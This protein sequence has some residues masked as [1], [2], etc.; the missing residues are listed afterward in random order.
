MTYVEM[1]ARLIGFDTTSRNSNLALIAFVRDYLEGWGVASELVFDDSGAKANLIAT[2]GPPERAGL[3][4]SGHTDVVPVDGQH[5]ASDPFVCTERD[6]RLHGRGA[7]D[8]K[9]FIAT[10]L[11]LVPEF[12]ARPLTAPI[13]LALSYDEEVGCKGAP[14]LLDRLGVLL[15]VPPFGA[16]I[17]EPTAMRVANGHK[18]KAGYACIVSGLA[19]HSALSHQG[20]NALEIAAEIIVHLRRRNLEF[21]ARGPFEEGFD[22]PHC[23]VTTSVIA[24]GTALNI[25][26]DECR[27]EFEF[28]TLPGQDAAAL[29]AEVQRFAE[30]ELFPDMRASHPGAGIAWRELMSYPALGGAGDSALE[31]LCCELA[32]AAR[33]GKVPFG[34]E[35]GLFARGIPS[36]ICGPGDMTVAHKPDEHVERV[37]L[38]RCAS[39]LRRLVERTVAA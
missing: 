18:G 13:H 10:V 39:F 22:P 25:V 6:G 30:T 11:A 14:R 16:V 4:L 15:P 21:R 33:P 1:L 7:A 24:G 26:P 31:L 19:C 8:M 34:T 2:L 32:G 28:R 38:E 9:G 36:V 12:L 27:F 17:G 23:T 5:W 35:A 29:L 20:V 3:V 37:E